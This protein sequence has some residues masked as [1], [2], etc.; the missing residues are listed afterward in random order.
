MSTTCAVHADSK[1]RLGCR[2]WR[3]RGECLLLY[4]YS[5][6]VGRDLDFD[7]GIFPINLKI[8]FAEYTS[9]WYSKN[10]LLLK[11]MSPR[12]SEKYA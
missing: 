12:F 11:E 8:S 7:L 9:A 2:V 3:R 6:R 10:N 1:H 5:V 4:R